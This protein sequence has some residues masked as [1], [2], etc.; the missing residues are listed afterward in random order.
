VPGT[1]VIGSSDGIG[2]ALVRALLGRGQRVTGVSRSPL[3]AERLG[4]APEGGSGPGAGYRHVV[5]DVRDPG[6]RDRLSELC[7]ELGG[8]DVCVYCAGVGEPLDLDQVVETGRLEDSDVFEVNLLGLVRTVEAVLPGMLA[9]GRGHVIGLSSLADGFP[10]PTAPSYGASKA[11]VSAY[12]ERL[13]LAVRA[14][15]VFVTS[16]R[17]GFVD[18]KMAKSDVRPFLITPEAAAERILRCMARRPRRHSHPRAMAALLWLIAWPN[19]LR[20]W[21]G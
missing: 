9:A 4:L 21:L 1:L 12:L 13:G 7:R 20:L 14:R 11:G 6:Y 16:V 10:D 17:F 8:V 18:T 2:L 15:G 5:A 3:P 19:R